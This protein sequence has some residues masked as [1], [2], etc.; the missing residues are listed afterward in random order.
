VIRSVRLILAGARV[1]SDSMVGRDGE[2][3]SRH[4]S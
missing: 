4:P 3:L 1:V 2:F